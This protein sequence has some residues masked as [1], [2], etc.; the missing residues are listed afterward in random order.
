MT[1][2]K[3]VIVA[4]AALA[5]ARGA[6]AA[7]DSTTPPPSNRA[8]PTAAK[9]LDLR[10]PDITK[11]YT[12]EQLNRWL[13]KIDQNIEEVEVRGASVPAPSFTPSVWGGIAAPIWALLHPSQA[14]RIFAPLPPDQTR[15]MQNQKPDATTGFLEPAAIRR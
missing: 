9:Q 2:A 13:A 8:A 5:L 4:A 7:E 14:W 15:G 11:L 10:A 1:G 12:R 6:T 3:I